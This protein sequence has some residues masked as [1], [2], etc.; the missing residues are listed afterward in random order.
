HHDPN[1]FSVRLAVARLT[2]VLEAQGKLE[3]V[4]QIHRDQ[5]LAINELVKNSPAD[6][7]TYTN[8]GEIYGIRGNWPDA[9]DQLRHA[10]ELNEDGDDWCLGSYALALLR[11]GKTAEYHQFCRALL[12][13]ARS[14]PTR[15]YMEKVT[16]VLLLAPHTGDDK[17]RARE[18]VATIK[19]GSN[20]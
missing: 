4:E 13:R 20:T 10:V 16:W 11:G 1:H 8:L 6:R 14:K 15:S 18:F 2:E 17:K 5:Y 7:R 12:E 9:I 3:E 19:Y